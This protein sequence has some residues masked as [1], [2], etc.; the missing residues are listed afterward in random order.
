VSAAAPV[1]RLRLLLLAFAT[2]F[3]IGVDGMWAAKRYPYAADSASYIE[4]ADSL[5]HEGRPRV[6][7]WDAAE[8]VEDEIPQRLFPPGYPLLI[9]AFIPLVGDART[10]ALVPSRVAAVLLPLMILTLFGGAL[11]TNALAWVAVYT[12]LTP[13]VRGWQFLAYSDVPALAVSVLALGALARGL[14]LIGEARKPLAWCVLAGFAAGCAYTIRNAGIAVLAITVVMLL[15]SLWRRRAWR[16][17]LAVGIGVVWPLIAL[18]SYNLMTFGEW[19]P[20][21]MPPSR[22]AWALNVVDWARASLTDA[23]MPWQIAEPLPRAVAPIVFGAVLCVLAAGFWRLRGYPKRRALLLLLA[24]YA[25]GGALLLIL[26]RS[27][28]E[29]GNVIDERNTLQYTWALVLALMMAVSTLCTPNVL[30]VLRRLA[31]TWLAMMACMSVYD[32]WSVGTAPVEW[33]QKLARDPRV[34]DAARLAPHTYLA[35]NQA[36]L[37]RIGAG[38][39]VRNVEIGGDDRDLWRALASLRREA[40]GRPARLLLIC[41]EYTRGFSGCGGTPV[42]GL[43]APECPF[44]REPSPRVLACDVP[45]ED[46]GRAP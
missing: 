9:A 22:R 25:S 8:G 39:H 20:Y 43:R 26:S 38:A 1:W 14:G 17:A 4:M 30:V 12:L 29:W 40:A 23:G 5:Y 21:A 33:W 31:L 45:V 35:S 41:D 11:S 46:V 44:V 19:Q 18:W 15:E 28:Y 2:L 32:A 7:P 34:S 36:V 24:G 13:G 10:A 37:F 6:T 3:V 16:E 27:R 42:L